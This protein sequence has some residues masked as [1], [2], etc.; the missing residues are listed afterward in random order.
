A[1]EHLRKREACDSVER[2][3][4]Q[5]QGHGAGLKSNFPATSALAGRVASR[6]NRW[7][8]WVG[9]RRSRS[10][11]ASDSQNCPMTLSL[12]KHSTGFFVLSIGEF[13]RTT[14]LQAA[15]AWSRARTHSRWTGPPH[16]AM[17]AAAAM[18]SPAKV[19]QAT[20]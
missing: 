3:G 9:R 10:V 19:P 7:S 15:Q 8:S 13:P 11:I 6:R 17:A 14:P 16:R 1:Q 18:D 5:G 2:V 20:P 4:L 12:S